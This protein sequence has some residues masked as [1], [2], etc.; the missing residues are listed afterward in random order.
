MKV[1]A[2][3]H[4]KTKTGRLWVIVR[5]ERPWAGAAPPAAIY[6]YSR[7]RKAEHAEAL[8]GS[9]RGFLHADGYSGWHQLFAR[10]PITELPRLTEVACWAHAR[11]QIYEFY[12]ST[13][14]PLAREALERMA[15]LFEIETRINGE[16][17]LV[18]LAARQAEAVPRLT[19]LKTFLDTALSQISGASTLA[20]AI[21]YATSRWPALT[22]YTTDGRLEMTNNAAER[23]MR[24]LAVTRKNF[25][26]LGSDS[27]GN[28]AAAMF[29]IIETC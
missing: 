22:R 27:G 4:G 1:L 15:P 9:C 21:R 28:R 11:R 18:R 19:E 24:P 7:D 16:T 3:G 5:D 8:L 12:E 2:P 29:S 23:A 6:R 13:K 20:R 26:F 10:D 14:A 25:L 17:A